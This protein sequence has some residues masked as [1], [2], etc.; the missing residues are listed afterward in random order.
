MAFDKTQ[1]EFHADSDA[2]RYFNRL[3]NPWLRKREQRLAAKVARYLP[4]G[5]RLLE[6]GCG[7]GAN[8][9]Y[10]QNVAPI[11]SLQGVDFSRKKLC[12]A[13]RHTAGS[14]MC[15]DALALP[16]KGDSFDVVL[17]RDILHHVDFN[18]PGLV[19]NALRV[20]KPGGTLIILE[21]NGKT[22]LNRIFQILY[23]VERGMRN[24]SPESLEALLRS[25]QCEHEMHFVEC[26]FLIRAVGFVVGWPR[27]SWIVQPVYA[28]AF[29]AEKMLEAAM[30]ISRWNY[31]FMVVSKPEVQ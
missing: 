10:L 17:C 29:V 5:G 7:E 3:R 31:C 13:S 24:S 15:A 20:L 18:R 30:P 21:S 16:Y 25:Y 12:F 8:I 22:L 27:M 11:S 2:E 6:V 23:P 9:H 19:E 26:S 28:V 1:V 14:Y 4:T